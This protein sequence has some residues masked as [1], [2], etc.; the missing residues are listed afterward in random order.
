MTVF[1]GGG[2]VVVWQLTRK[3][4]EAAQIPVW[5][6]LTEENI[7]SFERE[8]G[9]LLPAVMRHL[10]RHVDGMLPGVTDEAFLHFWPLSEVGPVPRL[11]SE[12]RGIPDYGGIERSLPE[13][14]SYFVFADHSIWLKVY[15]VQLS[16]GPTVEGPVIWIAG[17]DRWQTHSASY[18]EF[19]RLYAED[20]W[21]VV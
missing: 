15:A 21:Q 16:I 1:D 4:W 19:L 5:P 9:F 11:L 12:C 20:P 10:H 6:G 18:A 13:A 14:T 17:G 8:H 7:D 3:R 2:A